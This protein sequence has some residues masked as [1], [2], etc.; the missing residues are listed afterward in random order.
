MSFVISVI[1]SFFYGWKLTLVIL[2]CAPLIIIS[3]AVVAKMQSSLTEKE[4]KSYSKAGSVAEEVLGSIRTVI[5][6]GGE[7]KELERYTS[8]LL[9]AEK[10]GKKKGVF[11]GIGGGLMWFIIYCCYALAFWYGISLILEDRDKIDKDYTPA[12]LIIVLFGVLAGAQNLGL[13]APHLEAFST[14]QGSAVSIFNVIDRIPEIDS[15]GE[16]GKKPR[17]VSGNIKFTNVH[18][19]YPAR[20]DVQVL[21]GL[22]L[23]IEAGKMVALVGPSGC[24]KSTCL[25]LIQHLY[26]PVNGSVSIDGIKIPDWNTLHLRSF[27]GVVGQEPVLFATTIRENIRYGNPD[28]SNDEIEKAARI[29]NCH[30]FI[31]KLPDGYE[32]KIGE[33]GAQLSG[34]QKQRISI[35]RAL[36]KNPKILLLDEATSALDPTSEKRVQDALERASKG[37]TTIVVSHRLSTITNSDKI[38]YINKGVV[39]EQGT[40]AELMNKEGSYFDLVKANNSTIAAKDTIVPRSKRNSRAKRNDSVKSSINSESSSEDDAD[41]DV[42]NESI[43]EE[44]TE[45]DKKK[46]SMFSLIKM[47]KK[48]WP[49]ILTGTVAS[50]IVGA[51]FPAFAVLFGEMYGILSLGDPAIIKKNANFYSILF[52]ALGVS[53]GISTFIQTY[54]FNFAGVK[55]TSRLRSLTF[56]AMMRQEMGWFDDARNAVGALCARLAGDCASVQGATGS[57][58]GSIVQAGSVIFIGI[59]ISFYYNWKMT[60]VASVSIPIVLISIV[61]EARLVE[62]SNMKEKLAMENATKMAVEAI[63]NIRTV[64]SL[65]QEPHVLKRYI[66]EIDRIDDYCKEKSRYRGIVFGLGQTVPL[67]GYGLSLWYG[68]TLVAKREMPYENA[69]K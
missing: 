57:R 39:I 58:I 2:S 56:D 21:N 35:A 33:R 50:C 14:A 15:L 47:N 62:K 4:L 8:R 48:E 25:Q 41:S 36:V 3:T 10:N 1:F 55:L 5:A 22:N 30:Q 32:T 12:V 17:K 52:L 65:G 28:V 27:I 54:M 38:V 53:T 49:Y 20:N 67:M 59:G 37:R 13:T 34:G 46:V 9:P 40:H 26:N 69:I 43:E 44:V 23:E 19:R 68:G 66:S 60:L 18:F 7:K 61:M 51:S 29:S 64:A 31:M 11:S 45:E 63:G 16:N 24:G 6:F 42:D